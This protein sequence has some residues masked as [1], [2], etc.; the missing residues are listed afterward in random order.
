[1]FSLKLYNFKIIIFE[2]NIY[3]KKYF[4]FSL[5]WHGTVVYQASTSYYV[6]NWSNGL[7]LRWVVMVVV[8]GDGGGGWWC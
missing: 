8:G 5:V 1:M 2:K 3:I 4:I 6:W 7:L